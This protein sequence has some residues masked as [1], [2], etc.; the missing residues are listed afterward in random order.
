LLKRVVAQALK[1]GKEV[2][3][4]AVEDLVRDHLDFI[5]L[6]ISSMSYDEACEAWNSRPM[7]P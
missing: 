6:I 7:R 5:E 4:K 2:P 1:E 3:A